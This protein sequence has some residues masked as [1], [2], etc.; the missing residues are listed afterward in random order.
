MINA[1]G[2]PGARTAT[3]ECARNRLR[4]DVLDNFQE[5]LPPV[6]NPAAWFLPVVA[7]KPTPWEMKERC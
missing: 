6:Q 5:L 2:T 1:D 7:E 3:G 4:G